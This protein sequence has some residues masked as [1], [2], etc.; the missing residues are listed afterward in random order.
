MQLRIRRA[1]R[2]DLPAFLEAYR[3]AYRGLEEYSYSSRRRIKAYLHW[4]ITRDRD[5]V[6]VAEVGEKLAG[7]ICTDSRWIS[8]T[9]KAVG[10]VHELVVLPDYRRRGV[11]RRLMEAG[12]NYLRE[13]GCNTVELWVGVKNHSAIRFYESLGFEAGDVVGRWRRML[14]TF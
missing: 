1:S 2:G 14:K 4:L 3:E 13:K 11:A 9:G 7:F 10:A 12:L 6:F 8:D 5:G